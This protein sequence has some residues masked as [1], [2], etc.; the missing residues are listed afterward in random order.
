VRRKSRR[1]TIL[2]DPAAVMDRDLRITGVFRGQSDTVEAPAG[3]EGMF[4]IC[5]LHKWLTFISVNSKWKVCCAMSGHHAPQLIM[6]RLSHGSYNACNASR[7]RWRCVSLCT[8]LRKSRRPPNGTSKRFS[9]FFYSFQKLKL[10]PMMLRPLAQAFV[11][12]SSQ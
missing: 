11:S 6:N 10:V 4:S 8:Y 1:R 9:A 2:A 12:D 5:Y 7:R 3:F